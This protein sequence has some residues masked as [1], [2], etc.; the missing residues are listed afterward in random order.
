MQEQRDIQIFWPTAQCSI[1][2]GEI[3]LVDWYVAYISL[4]HAPIL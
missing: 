3:V 1:L 4:L 2:K